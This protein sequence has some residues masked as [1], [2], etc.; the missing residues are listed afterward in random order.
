MTLWGVICL[1]AV[2]GAAGS[3]TAEMGRVETVVVDEVGKPLPC[4]I[5]LYDQSGKPQEAE[6]LPFWRDH[7]VCPGDVKLDLPPGAYRYEIERGPEYEQV[8]GS[9]ELAQGATERVFTAEERAEI[10]IELDVALTTYDYVPNI[11]IIKNGQV[12]RAVPQ[13]DL[14]ID[15]PRPHFTGSLG[16]VTFRESGWFLVRAITELEHTFRFA[17]TAPY[18]VE[19]GLTKHRVSR[20]SAQFFLEWVD[21]RAKRVPLKL[22]DPEKLR[23]VLTYHDEARRFWKKK[24]AGANGP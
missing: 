19:I 14:Y 9:F 6:G 17:S 4:R 8:T 23:E 21:E 2:M 5:H 10:E 3:A 16:S 20:A 22:D 11:E 12:E 15:V 13:E 18:Y 7:F 1:T 24:V